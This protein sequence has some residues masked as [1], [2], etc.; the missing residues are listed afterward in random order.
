MK[1]IFTTIS[2]LIIIALA[3][4]SFT[5]ESHINIYK[6]GYKEM[7]AGFKGSQQ[8]LLQEI[9]ESNFNNVKDIERVKEQ[10]IRVRGDMK[11]MDF[12]FRY[13]EPV[14]YK[15]INGPLPVEWETEVFEKHEKPYKRQG[16]GLTLAILY[17]EDKNI[18]K[19]SLLHLIQ[20]SINATET[21]GADSIT[22]E[23]KTY[24]HFYL[25]NRLFLLNL[26]SIYTTGFECPDTARRPNNRR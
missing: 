3:L 4:A 9:Q 18:E 20:S 17:L 16:T 5:N 6:A 26:S 13:L 24:Q 23:L 21:F 8:L 11:S 12:W 14:A 2:L 15:K 19:D 25:C 22:S 7:L 1:K 10:I